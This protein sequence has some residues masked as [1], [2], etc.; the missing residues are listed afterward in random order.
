MRA[1]VCVSERAFHFITRRSTKGGKKNLQENKDFMKQY[2][3]I[4]MYRRSSS[5]DKWVR[6]LCP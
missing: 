5:K 4:L 2:P 6:Y 1:C 3:Y